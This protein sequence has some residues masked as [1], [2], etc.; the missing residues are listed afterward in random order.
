MSAPAFDHALLD[1]EAFAPEA[2]GALSSPNLPSP[3]TVVGTAWNCGAPAGSPSPTP[4]NAA[5]PV[6]LSERRHVLRTT[7]Q[8]C[9]YTP[10][11]QTWG[12]P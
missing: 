2:S 1:Q 9:I 6:L 5:G 3:C 10:W 8:G 4:P 11:E 7:R 12:W